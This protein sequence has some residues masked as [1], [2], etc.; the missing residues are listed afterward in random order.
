M[1]LESA[2]TE[3]ICACTPDEKRSTMSARKDVGHMEKEQRRYDDVPVYLF[4]QGTN[5]RAYRYFGVH[6]VGRSFVFRVW[7][8]HAREVFICG[9]FNG[10]SEG[11]PM[12][13]ISGEG[14]FAGSVPASVFGDG[15]LY[16]FRI[17]TA[18][19]EYLKADPYAARCE[20]P[21]KTASVCCTAERK[22][23]WRDG[24]WMS[25]RG[26]FADEKAPVNVYELHLGSWMR[27]SDGSFLNY[28]ELAE[29][30]APYVK[31]MGYTHVEL[32]PVTE[33]PFDGSWGYQVCG[34]YA[35]TARFG[36]PADFKAFV[37]R[38]HEAGIGVIL[39]WVPAHFPKDAHGL[40]EFD[41]EA[42]YEYGN[43]EKKEHRGWGTRKFDVGRNEVICFLISSAVFWIEEYHADGLRVDA[44]AS[45]IYLDYDKGPGEWTPNLYGDNRCLEAH[46]FFKKLNGFIKKEHPDVMMIAEES[47]S[48]VQVTG[49]EHDGLG[50]DLKWNMG[51]MN[52]TLFYTALDPIFRK[53]HHD[54][55]T[56]SM[57]YAFGERYMLPIS[58]DEVVHGKRSL[59][60]KMPGSYEQKFAGVRVFLSYM[61]AH[62]GKKLSFMGQEIGQFDEWNYREGVQWYLTD[63]A[64]HAKLQL[65][66][67]E[68]NQFYLANPPL[69]DNDRDWNGFQ[70][71]DPDDR[72][73]SVI[74]FRRIADDGRELAVVL[75]FTPVVRE[76]FALRVP[77]CGEYRE[78]FNSDA[79]RFGGWQN[80]NRGTLTARVEQEGQSAVLRL[81]LP[82]LGAVFL[83]KTGKPDE[84]PE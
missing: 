13:R 22:F 72:D 26:R 39:D 47:G 60:S 42:L 48:G 2:C 44:V 78:V 37:N 64:M 34:Y 77:V 74:S 16:K 62:P 35:P 5:Y 38:M 45:M 20:L 76:D 12:R 61:I 30:L 7:A 49:F 46:A 27:R 32:L 69:W 17:R 10:W 1:A 84:S 71:I 73:D 54:R 23:R 80:E 21:P 56:F 4:H 55:L 63:H 66:V 36:S 65:F 9:D 50:F 29:E 58:H 67:A 52:D 75:N 70:W 82:P 53:Y 3:R 15:S 18:S 79:E 24:G 51:W 59:L 33:H 68:L 14:I 57:V 31:M 8:P 41:G 40:Y 43:P 19:G 25:Y 83:Q 6:R 28:R 81:T 11:V